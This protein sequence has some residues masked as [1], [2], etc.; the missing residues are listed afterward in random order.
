MSEK[1]NGTESTLLGL[2]EVGNSSTQVIDSPVPSE[3]TLE[4]APIGPTTAPVLDQITAPSLPPVLTP[5]RTKTAGAMRGAVP[6]EESAPRRPSRVAQALPV[7]GATDPR[8]TKPVPE[9]EAFEWTMPKVAGLS[10]AVGLLFILVWV[11]WPSGEKRVRPVVASPEPVAEAPVVAT[12]KPKPVQPVTPVV[13]APRKPVF[14]L[15][16][17]ANVIDPFGVHLPD[18]ELDPAHK[19]RLRI[20]RDDSKLGT[21]L[22]RLDEKEGWGMMRKMASHAVLQFGG[23]KALRMHCDPGST[24]QEGQT[25]PLE[26]VDLAT[27]KKSTLALNPATHCWDFEVARVMELGEGVKKR[28]RVPTDTKLELGE[29]VQL[30]VAYVLEALG[31]KRA[32]RTGVLSPGESVL[33]EGR[34]ARF[35]ILDPYAGDNEGE[36]AL[37]LLAGDTES[38]GLVTPTAAP[39]AEFVPAAK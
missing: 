9:K 24:F 26:L 13:V 21:A 11:F 5:P 7:D 4:L 18:L 2:P 38:S 37:E 31:E 27:K 3:P 32:W 19:Y 33:A 15:D 6:K 20:E 34:L 8:I 17:R 14:K 29:K 12:P 36:L 28:V 16:V 30:R 39:G 10:G 25:F 22:A 1:K 23:A 35:A